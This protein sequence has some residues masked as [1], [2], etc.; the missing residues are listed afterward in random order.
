MET[1]KITIG[2]IIDLPIEKVWEL[3]TNPKHIINWNFASEDWHTPSAE[4]DLIVGGKFSSR[5]EAKDGS[6][7]FDFCGI[8]DEVE[9]FKKIAYTLGDERKV[10]ILFEG[11]GNST[12]ITEIF[13]AENENS[14]EMQQIGWQ[15]ILN[16]FKSYA[17]KSFI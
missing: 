12:Q 15:T 7:G 3:W 11:N 6:F 1:T 5:M 9:E 2:N 14:I 13:D 16:N 4:N 17:E 10:E 8:Y